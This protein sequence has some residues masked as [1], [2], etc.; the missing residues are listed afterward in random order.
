METERERCPG[1][2]GGR[3]NMIS[4]RLYGLAFAYKKTKLWEK[5]PDTYLFGVK[6]S[7]G[8]IGYIS[9]MGMSG[10][11]CALG[12]YIGSEGLDSLRRLERADE[13]TMSRYVLQ[14]LMMQQDCLQCIFAGRDELS[15]E[16]REDAKRYA[17]EHGIRIAGKNAYPQFLKFRPFCYP[18]CLR[19]PEDQEFLCEALEGAVEMNRLLE[20]KS[21]DELGLCEM[22]GVTG[23]IPLLERAGEEYIRS[24][25]QLPEERVRELPAPV[26]DND[27][28]IAKLKRLK[29]KGV[30]E[31]GIVRCP[32]PIQNT[33]EEIPHFPIVL[34]AVESEA[35]YILP[36]SP[37]EQYEEKPEE[38][39]NYFIEALLEHKICPAEI[40]AQDERVYKFA[41]D[42][43][44]KLGIAVGIAQEVP[45]LE[46]IEHELT[47]HFGMNGGDDFVG[48]LEGELFRMDSTL[49]QMDD[50]LD[51]MDGAL[52]MLNA[53]LD[54]DEERLD[55]LASK[56]GDLSA[57]LDR[58]GKLSPAEAEGFLKVLPGGLGKQFGGLLK[59]VVPSEDGRSDQ[60]LDFPGRGKKA[61]RGT[62]R[63]QAQTQTQERSF[64]ISVSLWPGCYRHIRI[65]GSSTLAML[66]GAILDAFAFDDDHAHAFFMDNVK[67]SDRDCYYAEGVEEDSPATA[68]YVLDQVGLYKGKQFK[69]VFDFGDEWMFQCKVLRI[70]EGGTPVPVVV[71]SKGEAPDQYGNDDGYDDDDE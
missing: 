51:K 1:R 6:L 27:I 71:K 49:D 33:P 58:N 37:V 48:D 12:L 41:E 45:M 46:E 70:V 36:V 40:R 15:E 62:E 28:S 32:E 66:H 31:C 13:F 10:Q 57:R 44:R 68:D 52:D 60:I 38:L 29:K 23:Q 47:E 24:R 65:A 67:W 2:A 43:G 18:W 26:A 50:E 69:Y 35:E 64:V 21:P 63:D 9:I 3:R 55:E 16:E 19:E 22:G 25:I 20:E 11:H 61:R 14:E 8:R 30:W 39:L 42:L 7:D 56:I 4:D 5:M 17:R 59:D 34:L 54:L 53:L